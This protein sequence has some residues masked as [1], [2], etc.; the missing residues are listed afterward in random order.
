I[1][2]SGRMSILGVSILSDQIVHA[3]K[4]GGQNYF[5]MEDLHRE[6][7]KFVASFV[8]TEAAFVVNSA[9]AGIALATA[10]V[11]TQGQPF[12]ERELQNHRV[13]MPRELLLMKGHNVNYG[14]PVST[15]I[16]LGGGEVKEI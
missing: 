10:G 9:S 13:T 2:A 3:I 4:T 15:M 1:N 11:I 16:E 14:A 8:N 5:V 12:K 6:A 7:G